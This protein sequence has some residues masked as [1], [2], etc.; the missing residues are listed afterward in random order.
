MS[1]PMSGIRILDFCRAIQGPYGTM[2]LAEMGAEVIKVEPPG[3]PPAGNPDADGFS[4]Y[5]EAIS[6]SK[7]SIAINMRSKEGMD[8]IRRLVPTVD[9]VVENYRA[10]VMDKMGLG[11]DELKKLKKDIVLASA[12]AWGPKGEWAERGGFDHVAQALSGIMSAQGTPSEPHALV[13]GIADVI[14]GTYLALAVSTA[15]LARERTGIGQHVDTSLLGSMTIVQALPLT[16]FLRTGEQSGFVERRA[17]TYSHYRCSDGKYIAIAAN[18]EPMW[19]RLA[20]AIGRP[21][22]ADEARFNVARDRSAHSAELV[23][24]FEEE[25]VKKTQTEWEQILTEYDVPNAPALDFKGVSEHPQFTANGYIQDFDHPRFG[26]IR[27]PG[28][29]TLWSETPAAIQ[30]PAPAC[31]EHTDS[32]LLASGFSQPEIDALRNNKIVA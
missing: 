32:V 17:P 2:L 10:G 14:G 9:A 7:K 27:V 30:G 16:Q 4:A 26:K 19:K 24:I 18:R 22:I 13:G 21:E 3:T 15:L 6:R 31:G 5:H 20:V 23:A 8:V 12:S 1:G 11:Y 28:P 29:P 25:F